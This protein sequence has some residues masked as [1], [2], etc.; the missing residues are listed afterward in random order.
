MSSSDCDSLTKTGR[1]IFSPYEL[2]IEYRDQILLLAFLFSP[3]ET[4]FS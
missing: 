3:D 1:N 2:Q 4:N